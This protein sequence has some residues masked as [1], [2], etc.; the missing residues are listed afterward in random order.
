MNRVRYLF[1]VF[2]VGGIFVVGAFFVDWI[3][4]HVDK[5]GISPWAGLG[6]FLFG[7]VFLYNIIS[8]LRNRRAIWAATEGAMP[9]DGKVFAAVGTIRAL[10]DPIEAPFSKRRCVI[11]EYEIFGLE[12]RRGRPEDE[13][14]W[15]EMVEVKELSCRGMRMT[16]CAVRTSVGDITLVGYPK[17]D[18][19]DAKNVSEIAAHV[20][21]FLSNTSFK[22][23]TWAWFAQPRGWAESLAAI[24]S[25]DGII[26]QHHRM[27]NDID[28]QEKVIEETCVLIN[29]PV[30]AIGH[31][32]NKRGGFI[33]M[34]AT[35]GERVFIKGHPTP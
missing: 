32:S 27:V 22:D 34:W 12:W 17:L 6:W 26:E 9:R 28:P 18:G 5:Q 31:F 2:G 14:R 16:P 8:G 33:K 7:T 1:L 11:F 30:C 20:K 25:D 4:P 10:R 35:A 13:G 3:A 15:N 24:H 29:E 19:F 21:E 23:F